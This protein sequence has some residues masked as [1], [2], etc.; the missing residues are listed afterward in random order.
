MCL[1][2]HVLCVCV[3]EDY[4]SRGG[5]QKAWPV[6]WM[7]PEQMIV[8]SKMVLDSQPAS[9]TGNVWYGTQT[10]YIPGG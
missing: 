7:A 5:H 2:I 6:R 3:Q 8:K 4:Y 10:M 1:Y 9:T